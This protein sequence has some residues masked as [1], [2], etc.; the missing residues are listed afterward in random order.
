MFGFFT[1]DTDLRITQWNAW[2]AEWTGRTP[3]S[4]VGR[5]LPELFPDLE[6]RGILTALRYVLEFSAPMTLSWRFHKY[7]FPSA[8]GETAPQSALVQP[9]YDQEDV[10]G[11]VVTVQDVRDRQAVEQELRLRVRQLETLHELDRLILRNEP[12]VVM[13]TIVAR[14]V[15]MFEALHAE[16]FLLEDGRLVLQAVRGLPPDVEIPRAISLEEGV[17]GQVART[18]RPFFSLD[19]SGTSGYLKV[20]PRTQAECAVPIISEQGVLYGVLNL[21]SASP[22]VLLG[23]GVQHFL[24]TLTQ[25]IVIALESA[26]SRRNERRRL[27]ALETLR[28]LGVRLAGTQRLQEVYDLVAQAALRLFSADAALLYT[29][30]EGGQPPLL[31]A[32]QPAEVFSAPPPFLPQ[33][34]QEALQAGKP[35]LWRGAERPGWFPL[36]AD[37]WRSAALLHLHIPQRPLGVLLLGFRRPWTF[38]TADAHTL[39]LLAEQ[40]GAHVRA[41]HLQE[42]GLRRLAELD[43]LHLVS[44]RLRGADDA[45]DILHIALESAIQV[46]KVSW[47]AVFL[48]RPGEPFLEV[49]HYLAEKNAAAQQINVSLYDSLVGETLQQG[50][51]RLVQRI[52]HTTLLGDAGRAQP[53]DMLF[54]ALLVPLHI[55][56]MPPAVIAAG[57]PLQRRFGEPELRL[58]DTIAQMAGTAVQRASL[59]ARTRQ[60]VARLMSLNQVTATINASMDLNLS[61]RVLLEEARRQLKVDAAAVLLQAPYE[62]V[63]RLKAGIG[64]PAAAPG[65]WDIRLR[66]GAP[67]RKPLLVYDLQAQDPSLGRREALRRAGFRTYA[68]FPLLVKGRVRGL[69]ECIHR[70]PFQP[71]A[72]WLEF[73][74]TL[75]KVTAMAVDMS[76]MFLGLERA[77]MELR[78]AYDATIEGWAK[79]LELRDNETKGHSDRVTDLTVQLAALMG[80]DADELTYVRWGALL[81]DIGKMG[82]PDSILHKAGPLTEEEWRIMRQHPVYAYNLL[83]S[84]DFL[85]PA[86][87]IPYCHHEKWDGSGYPQGLRGE[88]IPLPARLFA[89]VDV[90]DALRSDRPY[91]SAWPRQKTRQYVLEQSG[92]HFDPEVVRV[93]LRAIG[94]SG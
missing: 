1:L 6:E 34:A 30:E 71:D 47:V 17:V 25:Q 51:P 21:E 91:R 65:A 68:A 32:A 43:A 18:R 28:D 76:E 3:E 7:L 52:T 70:Q 10:V 89:I 79:A 49:V 80:F 29:L 63:L 78:T 75:A 19:V 45:D 90:W 16:I 82:I 35:R 11:M 69:L 62:R 92:K 55:P 77:N 20:D 83:R 81:H 41:R 12:E 87:D 93:F 37:G 9:L 57:A 59:H 46:L 5:S 4:V 36:P 56:D 60:Q 23:G 14:L 15:D 13:Q 64:L 58:L 94:E 50:R 54:D 66:E 48:Y 31:G 22:R 88:Q 85:R 24:E 33:E 84:I 40:L 38:E 42:V 86:L 67:P 2:L 44:Q 61:L 72:Y 53:E 27:E 26:A 8:E 74:E 39:G 73:A